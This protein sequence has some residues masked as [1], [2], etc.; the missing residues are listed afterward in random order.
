M[1]K[2]FILDAGVTANRP[3]SDRFSLITLQLPETGEP[4]VVEP[5]QFVEVK[6]DGSPAT[7]L[8]RPISICDYDP[9]TRIL[10][11]LIRRAGEGSNILCDLP[12]GATVNIVGP[13]GHGFSIPAPGSEALLAGGGVGVAPLLLLGKRMKEAGVNPSFLL[14]ART[15]SELL[16]RD[17]FAAVGDVYVSTDDG[18]EG[19]MGYAAQNSVL[20]R[21]FDLICTCGP[22]PMMTGIVSRAR[23]TGSPC[24]VS[25]E[26]L[27]ACGLGACL[28]CVEPT[29][30]GN[31]RACVEGPVFNIDQ[32]LWK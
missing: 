15:A 1:G 22:K 4:F 32:L 7:Y 24:E 26:N 29:L 6:V 31:L 18:S 21:R 12:A 20:D 13:L 23:Q 16:M 11:L 30:A 28:C 2:K 25:L 10:T 8:R 17:A 3:L 14:A 19:E 27:M 5:G 9:Q